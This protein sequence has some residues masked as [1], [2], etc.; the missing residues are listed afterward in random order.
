MMNRREFITLLGGAASTWPLAARA[1]QPGKQSPVI[2]VLLN[3]AEND[4]SAPVFMTAFRRELEGLGWVD[5]QTVRIAVRW[6]GAAARYRDYARELATLAPTAV[7]AATTP[8]VA[9]IREAAPGV[10]IVFVQAIDPVGS[11]LVSSLARPGGN[12]TGFTVYEYAIAA[13]WLELLKEVAPSVTRAAVL[14]DPTVA[15]G[16]GQFAAIQTVAPLGIELSVIS[17]QETSAFE[18]TI[19]SFAREPNGGLIVTASQFAA[20]HAPMIVGAAQRNRLP[21]V[22]PFRYFATAGALISYG[23]DLIEPYRRAAHYIDRILK[24]EKP[25]TLPVQAPTRYELVA[26]SKTANALGLTLPPTLLARAD[27]VIE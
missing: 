11:G 13:K 3:I 2:G 7:L 18:Q 14:R 12:A 1:E 5:G 20:N 21:V 8:A 10:P 19:A 27:E 25:G 23:P 16:I 24:G 22:T 15:A 9:A 17:P 4:P 6:A 26:N